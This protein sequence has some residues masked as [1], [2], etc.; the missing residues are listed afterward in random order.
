MKQSNLLR[1]VLLSIALYEQP[2]MAVL[3]LTQPKMYANNSR[4]II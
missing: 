3:Q 4:S 2:V 1:T